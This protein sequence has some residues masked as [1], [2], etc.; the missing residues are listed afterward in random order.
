MSKVRLEVAVRRRVGF[1]RVGFQGPCPLG[2]INH[3]EILDAVI[4]RTVR[5]LAK[6]D[7]HRNRSQKN[8]DHNHDQ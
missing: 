4:L 2:A 1:L 6:K 3:P 5:A 8:Y 7:W